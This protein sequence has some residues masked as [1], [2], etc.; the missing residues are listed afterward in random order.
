MKILYSLYK[1]SGSD[2][3]L[4]LVQDPRYDG[5]YALKFDYKETKNGWAG[6]TIAHE[7]D[8]SGCNALQFFVST[9]GKNQKTVIQIN[10]ADGGS[11]EAYLN[12]YEDYAQ[13]KE[14]DSFLVTLPFSEFVDKGDR[15]ALTSQAAA[16][17][18]NFGLWL[19]A[20]PD[21]DAVKE[22][23]VSGTLY[24]DAIKAVTAE[25]DQPVFQKISSETPDQPEVKLESV[26][27]DRETVELTQGESLKLRYQ[28]NPETARADISW[29]T[30]DEAV[31]TVAEDGTIQ[32]KAEGKAV[33]TI[34]AKQSDGTTAAASC[35][36]TVK[37][38][39]TEPGLIS[40]IR[41]IVSILRNWWISVYNK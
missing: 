25:S 19:N 20:I 40:W 38:A 8:W 6:A 26:T 13:A 4:S 2:L 36:V 10:T 27:L 16:S 3:N 17:L 41:H 11:Y 9:D 28:L 30:S 1:D 33:I 7:A 21:S 15:G 37:A 35:Q 39:D 23:G 24:Y 32:A 31:V 12:Q 14:G 5:E 22:D 18:S 34:T 29:E